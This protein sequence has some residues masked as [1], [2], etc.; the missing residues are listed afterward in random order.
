M[1]RKISHHFAC[2]CVMLLCAQAW[3]QVSPSSWW[4]G[5]YDA[6][7][8]PEQ[9]V[10]AW[11]VE[12]AHVS[13]DHGI[14]T[15][16]G[17]NHWGGIRLSSEAKN[18][19]AEKSPTTLEIRFRWAGGQNDKGMIALQSARLFGAVLTTDHGR[20]CIEWQSEGLAIR[21][22]L[23]QDWNTLRIVYDD[24]HGATAFLL[25]GKE[26]QADSSAWPAQSMFP[27]VSRWDGNRSSDKPYLFIGGT[28]LDVSYIRWKKGALVLPEFSPPQ[29]QQSAAE[30]S[31]LLS[32]SSGKL[33]AGRDVS[34]SVDAVISLINNAAF[35]DAL[36]AIDRLPGSDSDC[37][38]GELAL[39]AAGHIDNSDPN[40]ALR[41]A[42]YYLRRACQAGDVIAMFEL[43]QLD[44]YRWVMAVQTDSRLL[45]LR[46]ALLA[47][48]QNKAAS[49]L[50][51]GKDQWFLLWC[52]TE[53]LRGKPAYATALSN[54]DA[55]MALPGGPLS[56]QKSLRSIEFQLLR[57]QVRY[58][59]WARLAIGPESILYPQRL[60]SQT[61]AYYWWDLQQ[62]RYRPMA[63]KGF[64]EMMPQIRALFPQHQLVRMYSGEK[65]S[66]GQEAGLTD[67]PAG[68]P[69]WAVSQRE[70]RARVEYIIKWWVTN[71]QNKDG[72]L[73]GG[74]ED[75]CEVLRI[76]TIP[77][78]L[79]GDETILKGIERLCDGIWNNTD[80]A[81]RIVNGYQEKPSDVE[82][83]SETTADVSVMLALQ[84]GNPVFFERAL[85]TTRTVDEFLTGVTSTGHRHFKAMWMGAKIIR[86]DAQYHLDTQYNARPMRAPAMV[87]WYS[88]L[89]R[90]RKLVVDY[91]RSW[92]EDI[93]RSGANKPAGVIPNA[94]RFSDDS[95]DANGNW[96]DAGLGGTYQ[97]ETF[98]NK[99]ILGKIIDAYQMTGDASLLAGFK[100]HLNTVRQAYSQPA[101]GAPGSIGW[102][103]ALLTKRYPA[104]P[105]YDEVAS[106]VWYRL[107]TGD[108]QYDDLAKQDTIFGRYLV[109]GD[110]AAMLAAHE[111]ELADMRCNLPMWTTE[112]NGT[113]RLYLQC[114]SLLAAMGGSSINPT[115][116]PTIAVAWPR[117]GSQFAAL[118]RHQ[119]SR[120]ISCW[121][122]NF[123]SQPLAATMQFWRLA[124]GRYQLQIFAD[125]N[126][127]GKPDGQ[128][129]NTF[130][131]DRQYR[132]S[133]AQIT[134][135]P[136]QLCLIEV[137]QTESLPSL[138]GELPDVAVSSRDIVCD[139]APRVGQP[140]RGRVIVHNIGSAPAKQIQLV[141]TASCPGLPDQQILTDTLAETPEPRDLT[142]SRR[143]I[144]FNW[145][146]AQAGAYTLRISTQYTGQEI[147]VQNNKASVSVQVTSQKDK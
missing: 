85:E 29:A 147:N 46:D 136:G 63:G 22:P 60:W 72:A 57:Q 123:D 104:M 95:V 138:P 143:E 7:V 86:P 16:R 67:P 40:K 55:A 111:Q 30:P 106:A 119:D 76:W 9:S 8:A 66:W 120:S 78:I 3:P 80:A 6:A 35:A 39:A 140:V 135:P 110:P 105:W 52:A 28:H 77:A 14:L 68:V 36:S 144:S 51:Q 31:T 17:Q 2:V 128:A 146:P 25:T 127:D 27:V 125:A 108:T 112:L 126:Q 142:A 137:E 115:E 21:T 1:F 12:N 70:L 103:R 92:S 69:A 99:F 62:G 117:S 56:D 100:A 18:W 19:P 107:V 91:A 109:T 102:V 71:R 33:A 23:S 53:M 54:L 13:A 89:P 58:Y 87:A 73:G 42:E 84:Y 48:D 24:R 88:G 45:P 113:D 145:Q 20:P 47:G 116:T 26:S 49:I 90:A 130:S 122:Y 82:H 98:K 41:V 81:T 121:A 114:Y 43:Q 96:W 101:G 118:V 15:I 83:S 139:G 75:D 50:K 97:W 79:C 124:P 134:L 37:V 4:E 65:I 11:H 132:I 38:R 141:L 59:P 74:F 44:A 61:R 32:W 64:S 129:L 131:F 133:D 5:Q 94:V 34:A 10:P 93:L